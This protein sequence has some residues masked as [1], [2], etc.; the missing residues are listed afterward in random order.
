MNFFCTA[1]YFFETRTQCEL[2]FVICRLV[3]SN[4]LTGTIPDFT[5]PLGGALGLYVV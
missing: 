1:S 4:Q 3:G 2:W 5:P